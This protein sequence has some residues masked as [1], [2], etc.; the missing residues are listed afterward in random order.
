M[1]QV[2]WAIKTEKL[3]RDYPGVT[4]VKEL[5]F[6]VPSGVIHGFLGPN[7][8]GKSTTIKMLC[9]LL[10][11]TSGRVLI[12]GFDPVV[13]PLK[14]KRMIGYLP[15]NPPL[16]KEMTVSEY[17]R[18][19][20]LLHDVEPAQLNAA[21]EK[22]IE[23]T[24]LSAVS[25]RLVGN[26][27]KGFKQR[28]GIAQAII[29]DPQLIVLDEPTSGLDPE[30]VVEIRQLIKNLKDKKTVLLSSHL[31]HEVEEICD[32][33]SIIHSGVLLA[34][35]SLQTVRERYQ[36]HSQVELELRGVCADSVLLG[37]DF[38]QSISRDQNRIILQLKTKEEK[39]DAIVKYLVGA[40]VGVLGISRRESE[41]EDIF[42]QLVKTG[43]RHE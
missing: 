36:K 9:G 22:A 25:K 24:N 4:A 15:E 1:S 6:S 41:L 17:L 3:T 31:L 16:Y 39:R 32:T 28:V 20:A 14:V 27:S 10:R 12:E 8:A 11:P 18:F 34:N 33:I 30:S 13:D 38:V 21:L 23:L 40:G 29:H 7:G 43:D 42:L 5:D 35:G 37:M 2:S 26:L 19:A